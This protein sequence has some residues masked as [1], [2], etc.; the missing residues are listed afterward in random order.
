MRGKTGRLYGN[1]FSML[2]VLKGLPMTYNRNMQEDKEPLFDTVDTVALCLEGVAGMISTMTV[3]VDRMRSAVRS[4]FSTATDLADYLV[5]KGVPFRESH[6]ISG[7]IVRYCETEGKDFFALSASELKKFS[8]LIDDEIVSILDPAG[9]PERKLSAG[10][11]S[12]SSISEQIKMLKGA[13]E[14]GY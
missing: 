9:A 11:T 10:G 6:E 4:N 8:A 14:S 13:I 5:R 3:N 7:S 12:R 2:T 1:L